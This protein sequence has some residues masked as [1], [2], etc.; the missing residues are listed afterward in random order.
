M[1]YP[2]G[3]TGRLL[4]IVLACVLALPVMGIAPAVAQDRTFVGGPIADDMPL[5]VPNDHTPQAIRF[6]A[7]GLTPNT[8][9]EVKIRMSPNPVPAGQ[10]NRGF[11]WNPNTGQWSRNRGPAWGAGNFPIERTDDL[12]NIERSAWHFFKFG[13]ELDSGPYY[14]IIT[15][16]AGGDGSAMNAL[17]PPLVTVLD[18]SEDG[19]R[20]HPGVAYTGAADIRRLV[21]SPEGSTSNRDAIW[22]LTFTEANGVD[23]DGD[24]IVDNESWGPI[25]AGDFQV[26]V[27][28][29][30]TVDIWVQQNK[31]FTAHPLGGADESIA[32]GSSDIAAPGAPTSLAIDIQHDAAGVVFDRW[33]TGYSTAYSGGGYVYGRWTGTELTAEFT[34]SKIRWVGPKQPVYGMADV[35]IDDVLVARDVDCYAPDAEKTLSK[36]SSGR[37]ARSAT[38]PHALHPPQGCQEPRLFRPTTSSSTASRSTAPHLQAAVP[39][40]TKRTAASRAAG[41][42]T[43]NPTYYDKTYSYSRW[44]NA[45]FTLDLRGH[46][47]SWIGPRTPNYGMADVY[48]DGVKVA[49]VDQYRANLATQGL[50]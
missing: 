43:L 25:T 50:A 4:R 8:D 17:D 27:P 34:G 22:G 1:R 35:Y 33:V 16:A 10:D 28:T 30:S 47:V 39:A 42:T 14:I 12:G 7:T 29:T 11:T 36:R 46:R 19:T 31:R 38:D 20:V 37:A 3:A 15:L 18:M 26:A 6:T 49:T 45:T 13:N 2:R 48:I 32:L 40:T 21:A 23:D 24:G 9:Y 44:T 5:Y 41:C